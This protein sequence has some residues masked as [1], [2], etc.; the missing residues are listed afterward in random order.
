MDVNRCKICFVVYKLDVGG[1]ERFISR[2]V[3]HFDK[4][5]Y[6]FS[7]AC[8]SSGNG[9]MEWIEDRKAVE[10]IE[11]DKE[12]KSSSKLR[13]ELSS[14]FHRNQFQ[15]VQSHNWGTL[16]DTHLSLTKAGC[17][18]TGFVHAERGTVL[19]NPPAKGIRFLLRALAMRF[20]LTACDKLL[21]N[22]HEIARKINNYTWYPLDKI[23]VIPNGIANRVQEHEL[24]KLRCDQRVALGIGS[25][26]FVV[27][28]V[29]RLAEVKNFPLAMKAFAS[30]KARVDRP[31][32]LVIVGDGPLNVQLRDLANSLSGE[33]HS[34]SFLGEI[35]NCL[36]LYPAFD[37][38]LNSSRSEGMSQSVLEALSMGCPVLATD[39]GDH[40]RILMETDGV[41]GVV[42]PNGDLEALSTSLAMC[43]NGS[44][45]LKALGRQALIVQ[46]RHYSLASMLEQYDR[47][48]RELFAGVCKR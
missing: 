7:I 1:L 19:G 29:G 4:E 38:F 2:I 9:A 43:Y 45:D 6:Q 10:F 27:G 21:C 35:K 13:A 39:V 23:Q 5:F 33:F 30:L 41:A 28:M 14:Y 37:V 11:F 42:V 46:Q 20:H 17:K 34:I 31:C 3:N 12:A 40:R 22:A 18:R 16:G 15:I 36:N 24:Q 47:I 25:D 8:L 44:L 48:Y 26:E 32:R